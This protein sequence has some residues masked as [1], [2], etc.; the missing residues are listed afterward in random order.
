MCSNECYMVKT[1]EFICSNHTS[2]SEGPGFGQLTQHIKIKILIIVNVTCWYWY[3]TTVVWSN[4][5]ELKKVKQSRYTSWRRL[6][7]EV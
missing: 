4:Y 3:G 6:G 2:H 1:D 5:M 7:G